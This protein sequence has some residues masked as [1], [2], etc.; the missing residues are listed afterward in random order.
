M[1]VYIIPTIPENEDDSQYIAVFF[2]LQQAIYR[3][4]SNCFIALS[5]N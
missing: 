3:T 2:Y 1:G 5:E 4:S